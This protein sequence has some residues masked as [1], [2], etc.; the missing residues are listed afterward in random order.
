MKQ[1]LNEDNKLDE[2]MGGWRSSITS[3][4]L[5]LELFYW[6]SGWLPGWLPCIHSIR[7]AHGR[8]SL[9]LIVLYLDG[10]WVL[11]LLLFF[12]GD[13]RAAIVVL[14]FGHK[15][16]YRVTRTHSPPSYRYIDRT[17]EARK[18]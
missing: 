1:K 12:V 3:R 9:T 2:Q 10:G 18:C 16:K 15:E 13:A 17:P 11:V 6:V 8:V 4:R 14:C 5:Q 7:D